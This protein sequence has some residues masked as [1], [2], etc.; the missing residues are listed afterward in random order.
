MKNISTF[1]LTDLYEGQ[2]FELNTEITE[3]TINEFAHLSGDISP[4]HM[5][6]E[7]AVRKGFR[8]RLAHGALLVSLFSRL[9]GV[10]LPGQNSVLHS[11]QISFLS[12]TYAGTSVTFSCRISQIS[13]GAGAIILALSAKERD[14]SIMLAKGNATVMIVQDT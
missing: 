10:Y 3:T 7:F 1:G 13:S 14:T 5:D 2:S 4:I 8:G 6:K 9:I 11:I 12:P